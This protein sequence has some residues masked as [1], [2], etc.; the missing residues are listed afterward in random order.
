M[1]RHTITRDQWGSVVTAF[2]SANAGKPT[3]VET[4]SAGRSRCLVR[5]LPLRAL[6][7]DS[8]GTELYVHV[9][10]QTVELRR[11]MHDPAHMRVETD[12]SA[13]TLSVLTRDGTLL[14]LSV[15][16]GVISTPTAGAPAE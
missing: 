16:D 8:L 11:H 7:L 6:R 5:G 15:R 1:T 13:C 3:R 14:S 10:D 12:T 2:Q 9:G 4:W